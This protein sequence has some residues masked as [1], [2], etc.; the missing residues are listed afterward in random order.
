MGAQFSFSGEHGRR[1]L[2]LR[3]G[4]AAYGSANAYCTMMIRAHQCA[5]CLCPLPPL[6]SLGEAMES[7]ERGI[8]F[9]GEMVRA[10][11]DGRKT[12]TRRVVRR[13]FFDAEYGEYGAE[14]TGAWAT[15]M[16]G[17]NF[18][19]ELVLR[20]FPN[21][22]GQPGDRLWVKE[23]I[24]RTEDV[25]RYTFSHYVADDTPTVADAWPW[26]RPQLNSIHCPRG[27]SRITLEI[28]DVR[29]ERLQAITNDDAVQ[30]GARRFPDLPARIRSTAEWSMEAPTDKDQC[31]S[32]PRW[33]FANYWEKLAKD[34][35]RWDDNPWVWCITFNPL[36]PSRRSPNGN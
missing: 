3:N 26:K 11:L 29:V 6:F 1:V 18:T 32:G 24:R 23:T 14:G 28:T 27:L 8:L 16:P 9:S 19:P 35:T 10:I 34:G 22:Y 7:K 15:T 2:S 33:A 36:P 21:P 17:E 4:P 5:G 20:D 25:G 31:L 13:R 30:E 12:Q